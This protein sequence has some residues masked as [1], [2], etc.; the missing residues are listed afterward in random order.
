MAA[1]CLIDAEVFDRDPTGA[2]PWCRPA[3]A[4]E[5]AHL[6][7]HLELSG[8]SA[9]MPEVSRGRADIEQTVPG[10]RRSNA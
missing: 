10:G 8:T 6:P 1:V 4:I 9:A 5:H 7:S 3:N 2:R